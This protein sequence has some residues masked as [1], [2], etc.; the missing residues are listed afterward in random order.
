LSNEA[1]SPIEQQQEQANGAT[2]HE[3]GRNKF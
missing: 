2:Q 3:E 1:A